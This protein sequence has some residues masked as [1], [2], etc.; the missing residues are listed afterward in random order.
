MHGAQ[1]HDTQLHGAMLQAVAVALYNP[2]GFRT[3]GQARLDVGR[4]L[5]EQMSDE[6]YSELLVRSLPHDCSLCSHDLQ[7]CDLP[8]MHA[9][10]QPPAN[11]SMVLSQ[12][13]LDCI[14]L[15][16]ILVF[17]YEK[18]YTG[19]VCNPVA[20]KGASLQKSA[21]PSFS[22]SRDCLYKQS[23]LPESCQQQLYTDVS[24]G[25]KYTRLTPLS[26]AQV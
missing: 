9:R 25:S 2:E 1:L 14:S 16:L 24:A 3:F 12:H 23:T 21:E 5:P 17:P 10:V 7:F 11:G 22:P 13:G 18:A 19:V 4:V 20:H 6:S 26:Y 8:A 15:L